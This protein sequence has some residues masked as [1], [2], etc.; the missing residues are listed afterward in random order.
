MSENV[1]YAPGPASGAR[2]HKDGERWTL[3]VVRDLR[4]SPDLVW[5]ALT[6]PEH[7]REWAPFDTDG[8]LGATGNKVTLT[9]ANT[10]KAPASFT[11]VTRAEVSRLLE[12][13]WGDKEL[14]WELEATGSGTRLTLWHNIEGRYLAWGAA[15]W[16]IC[17]DVLDRKLSEEPIGRIVGGDAVK[18]GWQRLVGEY[19]QQFGTESPKWP[20]Q[21]PQES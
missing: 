11:T 2:V 12:Y 19:E 5:K 9:V 3:I 7:L 21:A 20:S 15:G 16:Q 6:E 17:F 13:N 1:Q 8:S 4:H 14:R 10:P 18:F